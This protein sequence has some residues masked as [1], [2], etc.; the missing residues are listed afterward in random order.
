MATTIINPLYPRPH[1]QAGGVTAK[2]VM[3]SVSSSSAATS[4][5]V[6]MFTTNPVPDAGELIFFDVQ[7]ASVVVTFDGSTPAYGTSGH[8][9]VA[10]TNYTWQT[11]TL[12]AAKFV[13]QGSSNANLYASQFAV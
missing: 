6:G 5:T 3:L 9:L 7:G 1:F 2:G 10:N 11:Q 8:L 13:N 4:F 12:L